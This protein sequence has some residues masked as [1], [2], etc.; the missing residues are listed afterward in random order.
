MSEQ[1]VTDNWRDIVLADFRAWLDAVPDPVTASDIGTNHG[2][3]ASSPG[4]DPG[5]VAGSVWD[6]TSAARAIAAALAPN[7]HQADAET[8]SASAGEPVDHHDACLDAPGPV[9]L[10]T[11]FSELA[12]LRQ[13][14]RLQNREQAKAV[15]QAE[16]DDATRRDTLQR[17]DQ[18]AAS[19]RQALAHQSS[20][21]GSWK[22]A[23]EAATEDARL[24]SERACFA[25]LLPVRDALERGLQ[26][27]VHVTRLSR[28]RRPRGSE[29]VAAGYQMAMERF[30]RS[31]AA[32]GIR[33]VQAAGQLFD[34]HT[35]VAIQAR[36]DPATADNLV[37]EELLPGFVQHGG[38]LLRAA[39]VVVNRCNDVTM[40]STPCQ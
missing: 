14:V 34:P 20:L 26:A 19:L 38:S 17:L 25:A 27:A 40:E 30:D 23:I 15:R 18:V 16:R 10:H 5:S 21:A 22:E 32:A 13:E 29:A 28:W 36:Q 2:V 37:L 8:D 39:E 35:M 6:S 33:R 31:M 9:D 11:L 4:S 7:D 3:A 12:A 1:R 24:A